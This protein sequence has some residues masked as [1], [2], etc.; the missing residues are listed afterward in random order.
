MNRLF[1]AL[2]AVLMA[3]GCGGTAAAESAEGPAALD[4]SVEARKAA[5]VEAVTR[6]FEQT[7][8]QTYLAKGMTVRGLARA[9]T[10]PLGKVAAPNPA[11]ELNA[12]RFDR[13][14]PTAAKIEL[15]NGK[16]RYTAVAAATGGAAAVIEDERVRYAVAYEV[17]AAITPDGELSD[18]VFHQLGDPTRIVDR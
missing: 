7:V 18:F 4:L 13:T 15:E 5:V 6:Q 14:A 10:R 9:A 1:S 11:A 8:R 16:V 2:A 17:E 3:S 12:A